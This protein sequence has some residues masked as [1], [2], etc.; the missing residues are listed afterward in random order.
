MKKVSIIFALLFG[1]A[2]VQN[3]KADETTKE[4]TLAIT[5]MT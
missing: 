1:I 2:F 3:V 4:V 5:G